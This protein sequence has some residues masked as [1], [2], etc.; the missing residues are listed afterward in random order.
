M[1][2]DEMAV[3]LSQGWQT[4]HRQSGEAIDWIRKARK[5]AKRLDHEAD[6]L[7]L[8]LRRARNL[9]QSLEKVSQSASTVGFF[10]LSQAGKSYLISAL[11][12]GDDGRLQTVLDG[13]RLDFVE[14]INP[15]GGGK[16]ATGLVTRFTRR[17]HAQVPAFP[18]HLRL[19][20][21]VEL[22]KVFVNSF[23]ND[24][25]LEKTG[26]SFEGELA[27][28]A[29][30]TLNAMSA[31]VQPSPVEGVTQ[32]DVVD[33]WDYLHERY[34]WTIATL[35]GDFFPRL[36]D[37]APFLSIEDRATL[38]SFL[39]GRIA[40]FTQLFRQLSGR[41]QQLGHPKT[42]FA[43]LQAL[44]EPAPDGSGF[45]QRDSIMNV[46]ILEHLGR[47][48]G[49]DLMVSVPKGSLNALVEHRLQRAELAALTAE[50][51]ISL[52]S[53][54]RQQ[55]FN[56]VDLLDFP[57]YRGRLKLESFE[58]LTGASP[59]GQRSNPIAQLFLRGKVAYLFERY[60][61]L[62]EMNV[63][64]VCTA[65][66]KQSD[67]ADVGPVLSGWIKRTQGELAQQR[68]NRPSG[69]I[70]AI[71]MFDLKIADSLT[72][73]QSM[74]EM[75]W[76]DL[77]KMTMLE[78]FQQYGWMQEWSPDKPFDTTFLVRK[79]RMP[80][81]FLTL[82]GGVEQGIAPGCE[83]PLALMSQT[84]CANPLVREHVA[85]PEQTW[86]A[87]LALNDGGIS[88]LSEYLAQVAVRQHKL[89]RLGEQLDEIVHDLVQGRLGPWFYHE[90]A[91]EVQVRKKTAQSIV[92]ALVPRARLLGDFQA[93]LMLS[94]EVLQSLYMRSGFENDGSSQ[95]ASQTTA[96]QADMS[97]GDDA[98]GLGM[99][100]DLFGDSSPARSVSPQK[101]V[102]KTG[103]DARFARAVLR[104]WI[105]HLRSVPE[106]TR[107]IAYFGFERKLLEQITDELITAID[108]FDLESQLL[109]KVTQTEQVGTKRERLVDRQ[110]LAVR[111]VLGDFLAWLGFD[112]QDARDFVASRVNPGKPL[113]ARPDRVP[114]GQWPPIDATPVDHT[115]VYLA[116]WLV[117]LATLI[118]GNAGHD[119]G[120]D[121]SADLNAE[122]GGILRSLKAARLE[123][124]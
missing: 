96:I 79:P 107:I 104:E 92:N 14:H 66:H 116:D 102:E 13:Q 97:A 26:F 119:A 6:H 80:V 18:L 24:F 35:E 56:S 36:V 69:L 5:S 61:D 15:P 50:L 72:K 23:F 86:Q 22:V 29:H 43:P 81:T 47:P 90:G 51:T 10:G 7:V 74:L 54:P 76:D 3:R 60:T 46:N 123:A 16:E 118:V 99:G 68:A 25:N 89:T 120:R 42:V 95:D 115:K 111:A 101:A 78:R 117:A 88:R 114:S 63:L 84:F 31:R 122:L 75:V 100:L 94:D 59:T 45:M 48:D 55:I 87:M 17:T 38:F 37:L 41:L 1:Q 21:E 112:H 52:A 110:V 73:S 40:G 121:I 124:M 39:W 70:W 93:V 67:V 82:E 33:L 109:E 44:V 53:E 106:N 20:S 27:Q 9:A 71:T 19:F 105:N 91:D 32:D 85:Q 62:Q 103:S 11:A 108:R 34:P 30:D 77:I 28:Q 65:S 2:Q 4:V 12:A 49:S 57:G 58:D 83:D 64:V 98:L 8:K 113:F